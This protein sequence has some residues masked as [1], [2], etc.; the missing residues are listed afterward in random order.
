MTATSVMENLPAG[1]RVAYLSATDA[2]AGDTFNFSVIQDGQSQLPL[3]FQVNQDSSGRWQLLTKM[4]FNYEESRSWMLPSYNLLI[5]VVDGSWNILERHVT[6]ALEDDTSEDDD[7][8]GLTQADEAAAGTSDQKA[9]TDGDG[10]MDKVEINS[11]TDPLDANIFP[12]GTLYAWDWWGR[13]LTGGL[14]L[15]QKVVAVAAGDD[16][17]AVLQ[18]D[19]TVK[20]WGAANVAGLISANERVEMIAAG[21]GHL[22]A[23]RSDGTVVAASESGEY[24]RFGY[25]EAKVPAD[26]S[27]V[28]AVAAG[29]YT[30]IALQSDGTLRT[31][32]GGADFGFM[33]VPVG[34]TDVVDIAGGY[35]YNFA[36]RADGSIVAWGAGLGFRINL[37]TDT[38]D[39]NAVFAGYERALALRRD[40]TVSDLIF[41]E[42]SGSD[43]PQGLTGIKSLGPNAYGCVAVLDSGLLTQWGGSISPPITLDRVVG[44]SSNMWCTMVIRSGPG[45]PRLLRP[46]LLRVPLGQRYSYPL[47]AT[48][49]AGTYT[50]MFLPPGLTLDPVTGIISGTPTQVGRYAVRF[51]L[52]NSSGWD[53]KVGIIAV[54]TGNAPTAIGFTGDVVAEDVP[55]GT[56]VA[57]LS[58]QYAAPAA[59]PPSENAEALAVE[60]APAPPLPPAFMFV[61]GEG[62]E[63]NALFAIVGDYLVT[64]QPLDYET[65]SLMHVR[66]R[67]TDPGANVIDQTFTLNVLDVPEG[68]TLGNW[69]ARL[70]VTNLM[71]DSDHDGQS[72]LL[73]YAMG[74]NQSASDQAQM[75]ATVEHA[76][77]GEDY[78]LYSFPRAFGGTDSFDGIYTYN[79]VIYSVEWSPDLVS[80]SNS[81]IQIIRSEADAALPTGYRRVTARGPQPLSTNPRQFMRLRVT[82]P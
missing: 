59:A 36:L 21:S 32:G 65:A 61:P 40:G 73:E 62:D 77:D 26:L 56:V 28:V 51:M 79:G 46:P 41:R 60:A 82:F 69:R 38:H 18:Q 42:G 75:H 8:D 16:V 19:G 23:L 3:Q 74:L 6:I 64:A 33:P 7:G 12:D 63:D 43:L 55:V 78:M 80:W 29:S 57:R 15:V 37:P 81:G 45:W 10:A 2:D 39:I 71:D 58:V 52:K 34:L 22:L 54:T 24:G 53:A 5:R 35:G 67:A 66:L 13:Q 1:T 47:Q 49:A 9:D 20:N 30:S 14:G 31:W 27:G 50:A 48:G 4:A 76:S 11:G 72:A 68:E 17:R 70:N 25:G 44:I